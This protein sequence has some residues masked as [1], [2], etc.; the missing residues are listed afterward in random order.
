[1][2]AA[3]AFSSRPNP[4]RPYRSFGYSS[5]PKRKESGCWSTYVSKLEA[6]ALM[7]SKFSLPG[8]LLFVRKTLSIGVDG[9]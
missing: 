2:G 3:L 4:F 1:M 9:L 6:M 8:I 7:N 5:Y